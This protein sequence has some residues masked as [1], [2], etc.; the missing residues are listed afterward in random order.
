MFVIWGL[1]LLDAY[2][3][4]AVPD[5]GEYMGVVDNAK[6]LLWAV[7]VVHRLTT[8]NITFQCE[9]PRHSVKGAFAIGHEKDG[10]RQRYCTGIL[11]TFACYVV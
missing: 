3:G 5:D 2:F 1:Q 11:V 9:D 7:N 4:W 8:N 10:D 6:E